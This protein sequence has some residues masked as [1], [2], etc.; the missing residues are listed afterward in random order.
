MTDNPSNQ[1]V[2]TVRFS[3]SSTNNRRIVLEPWGEIYELLI[4]Q[5]IEVSIEET[6]T[7]IPDIIVED[8]DIVL[9]CWAGPDTP[10]K[11]ENPGS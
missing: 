8:T 1:G 11:I 2:I 10:V 5:T 9:Y 3:N 7:G 6:M 4:G